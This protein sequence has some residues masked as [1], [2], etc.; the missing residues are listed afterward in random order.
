MSKSRYSAIITQAK[1]VV[2][3]IEGEL[4][5]KLDSIQRE[6]LMSF[7]MSELSI[8]YHEGMADGLETARDIWKGVKVNA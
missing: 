1:K 4:N 7:L 2:E 8:S 6:R 3:R 5:L